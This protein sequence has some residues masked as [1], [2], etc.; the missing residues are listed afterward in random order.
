MLLACTSTQRNTNNMK[1]NN[2]L[3]QVQN[4]SIEFVSLRSPETQFAL[5]NRKIKVVGPSDVVSLSETGEKKILKELIE[6]LKD[7]KRNWAAEVLLA[8]MTGREA[9]IVNSFSKNSAA[10]QESLSQNAYAQWLVWFSE[11][12]DQLVWNKEDQ[13]FIIKD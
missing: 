11:N 2:W 13:I 4:D 5:L 7:S 6:L 8:A 12:E 1:W 9:D 3:D 10:W